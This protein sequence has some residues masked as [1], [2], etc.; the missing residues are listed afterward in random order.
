LGKAYLGKS[1]LARAHEQLDHCQRYAP[2]S[3]APLHLVRANLELALKNYPA[4]M[5]ELEA[6]LDREPTGENSER[7]RKTLGEV[8][9]F[10]SKSSE[11][12][13]ASTQQQ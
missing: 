11:P 10:L 7:V 8:K 4:A 9:T 1:D 6:Y 5:A 13:V 12:K 2:P 3:Y